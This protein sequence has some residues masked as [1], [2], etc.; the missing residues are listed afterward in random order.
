VG[1][2]GGVI[3]TFA[4]LGILMIG[5]RPAFDEMLVVM[6][7]THQLST[8]ESLIWN[9]APIAIILGLVVGSILLLAQRR[10]NRKEGGY[11]EW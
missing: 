11:S 5:F 3:A 2:L 8:I 1:K 10:D 6:N 7:T 4:G 9:S